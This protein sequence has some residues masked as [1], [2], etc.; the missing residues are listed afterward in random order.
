MSLI[1]DVRRS[2][3]DTSQ[4]RRDL[5]RFAYVIAGMLLVLAVLSYFLGRHSSRPLWLSGAAVVIIILSLRFH[6]VLKPLHTVWM[7]V[8]FTMGWIVSRIV[9]TLLFFFII[10]PIGLLMR[11]FGKDILQRK[12]DRQRRS[13]WIKRQKT[14]LT[15]ER[16]ER[17]F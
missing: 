7:I 13:Y 10:T 8:A 14:E 15:P 5:V 16:Y 9:L 3:R 11:F 4:S 12:I 6:G 1:E 2:M 17:Q